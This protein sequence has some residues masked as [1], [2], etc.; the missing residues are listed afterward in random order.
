MTNTG[1]QQ[2]QD[3]RHGAGGA[4]AQKDGTQVKY[5]FSC[6]PAP[7]EKEASIYYVIDG[8]CRGPNYLLAIG[9]AFPEVTEKISLLAGGTEATD[10]AQIAAMKH[11]RT[12]YLL[13]VSN[14]VL[15]GWLPANQIFFDRSE[16]ET[17]AAKQRRAKIT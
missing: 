5:A 9:T 1:Q 14:E 8:Q 13:R 10:K 16:A 12:F 15:H 2:K 17:A 7:P 6:C 11:T 4:P 3:H